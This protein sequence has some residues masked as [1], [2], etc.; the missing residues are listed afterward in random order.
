MS[1]TFVLNCR[2]LRKSYP[3]GPGGRIEVLRGVHLELRPG[4]FT[5]VVGASGSGKSTLLH[6]LAGLDR[7]DSGTLLVGG[8]DFWSL[9]ERRRAKLHNR[10]FGFVYQFHHLQTE[11]DA[12]ENCAIPLLIARR[13]VREARAA[14][15]HSLRRLGLEDRLYHRPGRLS[16]G[17]RQRVAIARAM[18]HGPVC[19]L[20]DEPTGNL[21][22]ATAA[23]V[24]EQFAAL[25]VECGA[26]LLVTTHNPLLARRADRVLELRGGRLEG[27]PPAVPGH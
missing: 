21:D 22:E 6:L 16:G 3:E 4:E 25:R 7:P 9:S 12:L 18:V 17:E 26:A 1:E 13:P 14:A 10:Y 2:E 11:L 24:F 20:A 23:E 8:E 5:A 15:V 27:A 19:V